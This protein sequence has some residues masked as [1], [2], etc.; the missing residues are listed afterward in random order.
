MKIPINYMLS[1][2]VDGKV[3]ELFYAN[4][5]AA[6]LE[7][8][9]KYAGCEVG[10]MDV[11]GLGLNF[12]DKPYM[13]SDIPTTRYVR[14]RETGETWFSVRQC[15]DATGIPLKTLHSAILRHNKTDGRTFEYVNE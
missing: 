8:K 10:I 13:K 7:V 9:E 12:I 1:A 14:C 4:S 15:S 2:V 11:S 6:V 5:K 3:K